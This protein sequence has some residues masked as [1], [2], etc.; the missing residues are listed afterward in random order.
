M[1]RVSPIEY[2]VP[3]VDTN[4]VYLPR[5]MLT[6][7]IAPDPIPVVMFAEILKNSCLSNCVKLLL[8][9]T[10]VDPRIGKKVRLTVLLVTA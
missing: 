9:I 4:A 7:N 6:L 1:V 8:D 2:K 10:N 5:T 3:L